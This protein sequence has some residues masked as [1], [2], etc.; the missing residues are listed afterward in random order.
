MSRNR[1]SSALPRKPHNGKLPPKKDR[2]RMNTPVPIDVPLIGGD[3]RP[4]A[5][6]CQFAQQNVRFAQNNPAQAFFLPA[7][8]TDPYGRPVMAHIARIGGLDDILD[9]ARLFFCHS[10][11]AGD[12]TP[13]NLE[14]VRT[15]MLACLQQARMLHDL[16]H[17]SIQLEKPP[18]KRD[19][20]NP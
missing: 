9:T 11:Y 12:S 19:F 5:Q 18:E 7:V 6:P 10:G 4:P 14:L 15:A 2:K 3:R 20:L 13:G 16:Y 1:H 8:D 17:Q